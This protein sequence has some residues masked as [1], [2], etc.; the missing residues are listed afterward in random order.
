MTDCHLSDGAVASLMG[1]WPQIFRQTVYH[2]AGDHYVEGLVERVKLLGDAESRRSSCCRPGPLCVRS[3]TGGDGSM[4]TAIP[5]GITALA[6]SRVRYPVPHPT[7]STR[8]PS[9]APLSSTRRVNAR[10]R[11]SAKAIAVSRSYPRECPMMTSGGVGYGS[12]FLCP[13]LAGALATARA[14]HFSHPASFPTFS[15]GVPRRAGRPG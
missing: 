14:S 10:R 9:R 2:E 8:S 5:P 12:P 11:R 3:T 13:A 7:S 6:V 1:Q 4:P 15:P